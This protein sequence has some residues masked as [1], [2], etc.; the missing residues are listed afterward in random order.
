MIRFLVSIVAS[1]ALLGP[2]TVLACPGHADAEGH[3]CPCK[4]EK[5]EKEKGE[6]ACCAK[7]AAGEACSCQ[8]EGCSHA[9]GEHGK[10]AGC[11][12]DHADEA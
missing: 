11:G 2:A 12:C 5:H 10:G 3:A 8:K 4:H 7:K 6:K 9:K 1:L